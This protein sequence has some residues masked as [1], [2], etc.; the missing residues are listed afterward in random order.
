MTN[1]YFLRSIWNSRGEIFSLTTILE[2]ILGFP[3]RTLRNSGNFILKFGK[4]MVRKVNME[5]PLRTFDLTNILKR[6][7]WLNKEFCL[8]NNFKQRKIFTECFCFEIVINFY[9]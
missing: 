5:L 1:K 2:E 9:S 8:P 3:S 7:L 6:I 4:L